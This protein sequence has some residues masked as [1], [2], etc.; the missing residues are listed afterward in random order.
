MARDSQLWPGAGRRRVGPAVVGAAGIVGL[1]AVVA[2]QGW[3]WAVV[4]WLGSSLFAFAI[5]TAAA[6]RRSLAA[7]EEE[8]RL[9]REHAGNE[10]RAAGTMVVG[11]AQDPGSTGAARG[12]T[13]HN[14][15]VDRPSRRDHQS[16]DNQDRSERA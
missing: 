6:N 16:R 1:S 9:L 2:L 7:E 11:S 3:V 14:R 13:R 12:D 8:R 10:V 5:A 4:A 15:A